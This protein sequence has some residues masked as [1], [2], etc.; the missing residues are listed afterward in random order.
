MRSLL[1]LVAGILAGIVAMMAVG[2]IGSMFFAVQGP[3]APAGSEALATAIGSAPVATQ[4][5]ILLS[6]IAAAFAGAATA[7]AISRASWPG[8]VIAG[9]LALVLA[10]TFL[11]PF[12]AWMQILAVAGPLAAGV[13]ADVLIK[14][15]PAYEESETVADA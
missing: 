13:L 2:W 4:V 12:P 8:W 15:R 7:K 11:V 10:G 14:G 9:A 5:T 3:T 1:G 6:W